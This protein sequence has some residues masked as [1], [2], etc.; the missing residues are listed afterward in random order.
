MQPINLFKFPN[1]LAGDFAVTLIVQNILTWI[2][3]A[4]L[5]YTDI[6]RRRL[7]PL[8]P[9]RYQALLRY[10]VLVNP[11]SLLRLWSKNRDASKKQPNVNTHLLQPW[12][13]RVPPTK[14][15]SR[16]LE[17]FFDTPDPLHCHYTQEYDV[18]A[19][20]AHVRG[21]S[22]VQRPNVSGAGVVA[23]P[24][25]MA[26]VD[27]DIPLPTSASPEQ[28]SQLVAQ[29]QQKAAGHG[30]F[31]AKVAPG[32][33][34]REAESKTAPADVHGAGLAPA[35]VIPLSVTGGAV[36]EDRSQQLREPLS[37]GTQARAGGARGLA[38]HPDAQGPIAQR[39]AKTVPVLAGK[40]RTKAVLRSLLGLVARGFVIS[41]ITFIPFWGIAV[42]ICAAI[43]GVG[44]ENYNRFPQVP[45]I[46]AVYAGILGAVT[47][48]ILAISVIWRA[49]RY[50]LPP[51]DAA[52]DLGSGYAVGA[53]NATLVTMQQPA[54]GAPGSGVHAAGASQQGGAVGQQVGTSAPGYSGIAARG[55][56]VVTAA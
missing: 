17:W 23:E 44:P 24:S 54:G 29:H 18:G 2:I 51:P 56:P 48:P 13:A 14:K 10:V 11:V 21:H 19:P 55:P 40:A 45:I 30:G 4:S 49:S 43:W 15:S 36:G 50:A 39:Y 22:V 52:L 5:A 6:W 37:P 32:A 53:T 31:G 7:A 41:V 25:A 33:A 28:L 3:G 46:F 27:L 8:S 9:P 47:T 16:W 12:A 35:G 1:T 42:G 38:T 26:P 34:P 20:R